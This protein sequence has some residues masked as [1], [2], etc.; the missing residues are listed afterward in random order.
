MWSKVK[1]REI[2]DLLPCNMERII[3]VSA[4]C[5]FVD[6]K[7]STSKIGVST[8]YRPLFLGYWKMTPFGQNLYL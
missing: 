7:K 6:L 1:F 2:Y 4:L 5:L 3:P 8:G